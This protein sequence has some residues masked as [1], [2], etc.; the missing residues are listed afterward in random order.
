MNQDAGTIRQE[1][2]TRS[3]SIP[4]I[5]QLFGAML[6]GGTIVY[7]AGFVNADAVHNAAHDTRHAEGFP[8]H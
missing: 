3:L 5:R 2:T 7:A 4:R 6:L 1:S 8:C